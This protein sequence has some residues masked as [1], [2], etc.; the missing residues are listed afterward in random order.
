MNPGRQIHT[1]PVRIPKVSLARAISKIGFCSRT[2]A[3]GYIIEGRVRI[4]GAISRDPV[5]RVDLNLDRID[6]DSSSPAP[7]KKL[8][9]ML[10][11]PRG[12]VVTASDE[13][14]RVTVYSCFRETKFPWIAPVGRLDKASEGLLL[15]TNDTSWAARILDPETHLD[16]IY[17]VQINRLAD[18]ELIRGL[19]E[20]RAVENG[21]CL[22]AKE[23]GVL[24][25]GIRNSWLEI[26]LDEGKNRHI[27]RL[28]ASLGVEVL[29]LV[30]VG[31]GPLILGDLAR[32]EYRHLTVEEVDAVDLLTKRF[33][34]KNPF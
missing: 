11:K 22:T 1:G 3:R 15:F 18:G 14:G 29:R 7:R 5:M 23:A 2:K 24:R 10:N 32:G 30:R 33:S 27:R 13:R 28:L 4:N 25:R 31:I 6:V 34:A 9:I 17:H 16:K 21:V 26:V 20:G 12:F 19:R 8:Y